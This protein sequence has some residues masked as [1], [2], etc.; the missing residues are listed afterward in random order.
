MCGFMCYDVCCCQ[1]LLLV[2]VVVAEAYEVSHLRI[3]GMLA[4]VRALLLSC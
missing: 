1:K 3:Y 4:R 2:V